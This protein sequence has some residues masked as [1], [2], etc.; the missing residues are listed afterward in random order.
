M[1]ILLER[2]RFANDT[3]ALFTLLDPLDKDYEE[4]KD[5]LG[6]YQRIIL[7]YYNQICDWETNP[8]NARRNSHHKKEDLELIV[9]LA[10]IGLDALAKKYRP[11]FMAATYL[12]ATDFEKS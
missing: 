9:V 2:V 4:D 1:K 3:E 10:L 8:E 12:I 6:H 11:D 7:R 5:R